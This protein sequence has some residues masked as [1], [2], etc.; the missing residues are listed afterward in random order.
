MGINVDTT[1]SFTF[2]LG[3]LMAGA[4]GPHLRAL[5]DRRL[6][7]RGLPG[8]P[9]RLHRRRDG[10]HRQPQ[11]RRARRPDHRRHPADLRQPHRPG[12]DAGDRLRV[13]D[14]D[15]GLPARRACSARR[16]GRPDDRCRDPTSAPAGACDRR[17]W[18]ARGLSRWSLASRSCCRSSSTRARVHRRLAARAGLRG[19]GARAERHRRLRRPAR[20]RVRRLLRHRRAARRLVQLELLRT[21]TS[22]SASEQLRSLPGIHSTSCDHRGRRGLARVLRRAVRRRRRCACAATTSRS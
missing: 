19:D 22:T 8:R 17:P 14:A 6:V 18:S 15:H 10:R 16:R 21:P 7:L 11:G 5:P 12:V 1:I 13:P 4:A 9:D 3:G 2:L 20:P